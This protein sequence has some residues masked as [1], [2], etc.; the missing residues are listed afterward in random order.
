MNIYSKSL[1]RLSF[2]WAAAWAGASFAASAPEAGTTAAPMTASQAAAAK[3][4]N[5]KAQAENDLIAIASAAE[6]KHDWAGA[7][8]ALKQL[9]TMDP[10]RWDFSQ[11]LANDQFNQGKFE[12]AVKSYERAIQGALADTADPAAAK[13]ALPALYTNQGN[14]YLKLKNNTAATA[15]FAKAGE[16]GGGS[17]AA[18]SFYNLCATAYNAHKDKEALADCDKAIA[19]NPKMADAW[20]VKGSILANQGQTDA[21]GNFSVPPGT[22]EALKMYLKLEPHGKHASEVKAMLQLAEP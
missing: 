4:A 20:F 22:L 21:N 8:V 3:A 14:A 19:A 17:D 11:S 9:I 6:S 7:E 5:V 12:D 1:L 18:T 2:I 15:D 16:L 13:Q 10:R